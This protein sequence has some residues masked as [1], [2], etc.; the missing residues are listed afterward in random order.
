MG[1]ASEAEKTSEPE[2]PSESEN[3]DEARNRTERFKPLESEI[4][5]EGAKAGEPL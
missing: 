2:Y 3:A 4:A 5:C 1:C